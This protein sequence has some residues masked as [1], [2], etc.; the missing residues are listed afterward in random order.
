MFED[1]LSINGFQWQ[2]PETDDQIIAQ[3]MQ[4]QDLPEFIARLLHVRGVKPDDV[5][6]F[7]NPTLRSHFPDPFSLQGMDAFADDLSDAILSRRNI[8]ILADFDVDGATSAAI[9]T[10]FL[11][12]FGISSEV[13]IPDRLTEGY[14]PSVEALSFLKEKGAEYVLIADC[15]TTA[16]DVVKA[17]QDMGLK[18]SIFDHHE[19]EETL[20]AADHVINPKRKDDKSG[21]DMLAA[22]GVCFMV[23]VALNNRLREKG[24][25]QDQEEPALKDWLDLV[26][27]GTVCDMVPMLGVN[28]LFVRTGFQLMAAHKNVGIK[29]LCDM[30][31]VKN[32]PTPQHAGFT[33]GPRIN[34]GSRV[35]RSDLGAKLLSTDNVEEAQSIALELEDC[36]TQR[37][38]IQSE[39]N[40]H[41]LE[42]VKAQK[43]DEKPIIIVDDPDWHPGLS[44]LVA[45]RLKDRFKKPAVVVTYA[46]TNDGVLEGRGSGRSVPGVSMADAF[47]VARAQDLIVKGGGHA[48]AGGFTVLPDKIAAL[49]DFLYDYVENLGEESLSSNNTQMIDSFTTIRGIHVNTVKMIDQNVGPFGVAHEEPV[50]GL[51]NVKILQVDILKDKHIRALITDLEGGPRI[52][53]LLFN[54]IGTKLGDVLVKGRGLPFH[55]I[56]KFQVNEWQGYESVD[57]FIEDAIELVQTEMIVREQEELLS[58]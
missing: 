15:G 32:A 11:R 44:G 38:Q 56:G 25:F 31:N 42:L 47:M 27:L 33:I 39:M 6:E 7:L 41:A 20:P 43:L 55:F 24:A 29:A 12:H 53:A 8:A 45:G 48:M 49:R 51:A 10:R 30:G 54:G 36:N 26:A 19:A 14:G 46:Q 50:F 52:K 57:F 18:I 5:T 4:K 21:L 3:I 17:G 28:R 1:R 13:Y 22:C 16:F 9:L 35:H 37:R 34:A 2:L 58:S 23:C 40:A